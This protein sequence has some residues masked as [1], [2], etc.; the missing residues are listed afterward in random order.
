LL[1]C[2]PV[3]QIFPWEMMLTRRRIFRTFSALQLSYN[4]LS[5]SLTE[6]D[7]SVRSINT[8][9]KFVSKKMLTGLAVP[10]STASMLK[11]VASLNFIVYHFD[12]LGTNNERQ[13]VQFL[14][15]FE[16]SQLFDAMKVP[17]RVTHNITGFP[18]ET[19]LTEVG[20]KVA[21]LKKKYKYVSFVDL[22][23]FLKKRVDHP[24]KLT[25]K[26]LED[27]YRFPVIV[28][29]LSDLLEF[30]DWTARLMK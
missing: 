12:H 16:L 30:S 28:L 23:P 26:L 3:F 11:H 13:R 29:P 8:I 20:E 18:F 21:K 6:A 17:L 25:L 4:P 10:K 7:G 15:E 2:S 19:P 5:Q 9:E 24:L 1:V 22:T 14:K 27:V